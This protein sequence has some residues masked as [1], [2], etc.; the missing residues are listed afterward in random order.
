MTVLQCT[1][2]PKDTVCGYPVHVLSYTH[3]VHY[4]HICLQIENIFNCLKHL[5]KTLHKQCN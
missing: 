5:I 4:L 3:K 1:F 2:T